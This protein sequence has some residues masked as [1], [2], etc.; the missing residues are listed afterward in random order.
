[1]LNPKLIV[2]TLMKINLFCTGRKSGMQFMFT[3]FD[4]WIN[5]QTI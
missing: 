3:P 1:M 5:I 4:L 2:I